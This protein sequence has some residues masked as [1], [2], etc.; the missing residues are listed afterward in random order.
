VSTAISQRPDVQTFLRIASNLD[1]EGG[2]PRVKQV[3]HRILSDVFRM[4]EDLD[5][6]PD[7]VWAGV[8]YLN[9]V[10]GRSEAALLAAGLGLEHFLDLRLD[11]QDAQLGIAAG[12]PRTIEGPLYVAGAPVSNRT[13]RLDRDPDTGDT[14]FLRGTIRGPEG[15][16]VEGALIEAWHANSKGLY[17]HYDPTGMQSAFNLR[18]GVRVS[19]DGRYE[20]QTLV[21]VGYGCPPDGPTLALLHRIGRHGNRPAHIH[22]FVTAPGM[23]KLTTQINLADDPLVHDDFAYA[24]REGLIPPMKRVGDHVEIDFDVVLTPL[25]AGEDNQVVDRR[26]LVA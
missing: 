8:N 19:V 2:N 3:V 14:L 21:P 12:T 11:E 22:L 7:E 4:I 23:R 17:S 20:L 10:G 25:V 24:T 5:L 18:G 15:K 13:A 26:R 6:K 9:D 1:R 16:P